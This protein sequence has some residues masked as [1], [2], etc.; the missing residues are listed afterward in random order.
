MDIE[1]LETF[2]KDKDGSLKVTDYATITC[3]KTF[4]ESHL[5]MVKHNKG[6][7]LFEPYLNRLK[8]VKEILE[9]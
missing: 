5:E 2:F 6:K 8:K 1:E 4:S 3:L 9:L 7:V